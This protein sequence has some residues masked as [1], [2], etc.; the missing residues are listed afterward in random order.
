MNIFV[1]IFLAL[2]AFVTIGILTVF[3]FVGKGIRFFR[4]FSTGDMSD[5]EFQRMANKYYRKAESTHG[6][7]AEDY[8][9]GSD[10]RRGEGD[11]MS[12]NSR[13]ETTTRTTSGGITIEDHRASERAKKKIFGHDEGEY[14]DFTES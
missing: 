13:Q 10:D 12:G 6:E 4:R 3:Y 14:V 2:L 1:F 11:D 9:R 5:E 8:F 7:F